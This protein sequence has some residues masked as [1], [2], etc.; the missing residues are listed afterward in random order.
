MPEGILAQPHSL[1]RA[2]AL[3]RFEESLQLA[4]LRLD[5]LANLLELNGVDL[6][7]S[8]AGIQRL[9]EWFLANVAPDRDVPGAL[10][11]E[12]YSVAHDIALFLGNVMI[13]RDENLRWA[14]FVW[15][16]SN[17]AFHRGVI[18]GLSSED[19]KLRTNIDIDRMVTSYAHQTVQY[20]GSIPT[21]GTVIIRGVDVDVDEVA[22]RHRDQPT[23]DSFLQWLGIAARRGTPRSGEVG[24][25]PVS[26]EE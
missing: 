1:S 7:G 23:S 14:L 16:K 20:R 3:H 24:P 6:E 19:P 25:R 21:W 4:P 15:G 11:R 13:E 22:S 5:S 10:S 26:A 9:N 17:V 8:D 2:Q 12:W 18:V